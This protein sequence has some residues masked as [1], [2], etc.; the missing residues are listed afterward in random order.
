MGENIL[1]KNC[2]IWYARLSPTH[3]NK[4]KDGTENWKIIIRT[5]DIAVKKD[6][7]SKNLKIKTRV[8]DDTGKAYFTVTL[9]KKVWKQKENGS[10]GSPDYL[11]RNKPVV[12]VNGLLQPIK[13]DTIGNGSIGN[14]QVWQYEHPI[15]DKLGNIIGNGIAS[16]L[17][18]IQLL[19][20]IVYEY[21]PKEVSP[22]FGF[23]EEGE[24]IVVKQEEIGNDVEIY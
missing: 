22:G 1:I 21:T 4:E 3:P 11:L 10:P 5:D 18:K 17:M 8:D 14:I 12:V 9:R 19:K 20:H 16:M 15:K 2:E 23:E 24:T 6:W 7:V 13:E